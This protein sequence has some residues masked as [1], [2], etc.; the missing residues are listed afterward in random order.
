M[1]ILE[2]MNLESSFKIYKDRFADAGDFIFFLVGNFELDGIKPLVETYLESLPT[3]GREET[4]KDVGMDPPVGIVENSVRKGMEPKSMVHMTFTDF[5]EWSPENRHILES[6]KNVMEIKLREVMREDMGGTYGVWM[7]TSPSHYPKERYKFN[8]RFGCSPENV[9]T[10]TQAV[11]TQIDS[12]QSYG[13]AADYISKVQEIQRRER[14][15]KLKENQFWLG[16][17]ESYYFHGEDP[18]QILNYDQLVDSINPDVIQAAAANYL[19]LE[20]YMKITL[21]PEVVE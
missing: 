17:L 16:S 12:I 13:I 2:E 18:L 3:A 15:T 9:D 21:Y 19:N 11:F 7:W 8:I 5:F 10:L 6:L 20:N 1:E 14:E 4:W